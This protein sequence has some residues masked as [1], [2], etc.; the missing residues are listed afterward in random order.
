MGMLRAVSGDTI[1]STD[2]QHFSDTEVTDKL[3]TVAPLVFIRLLR[4]LLFARVMRCAPVV[5][6]QWLHSLP[7]SATDGSLLLSTAFNG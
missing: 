2:G 5:L 4:A 3:E 1:A 6:L 7:I